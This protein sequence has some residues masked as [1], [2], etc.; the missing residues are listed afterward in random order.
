MRKYFAAIVVIG[1]CT[2]PLSAEL[3]VTSKMVARQVAGA[4]AGNDMMAAMVGPMIT[5]MYGGADGV[6]MIV[7]MHEDGRMRTDY[8]KGFAGMPAGAVV[9]LRADGSSVGFDDKARTWWKMAGPMD[10]PNA[11]AMLAQLKPQVATKR[12]GEFATIAGLKAERVSMTMVMAVPLPPGAENMPP[13]MMAMIPKEI[14]VEGDN[15]VAQAHAKYMKTMTKVLAQGPL[16]GVGIDK[17]L[18]DLQ[19]LS[20]RQVVRMSML[21]GWEL[22]TLVT[23]VAEEDTPDTVFDLPSGYKEIPMPTPIR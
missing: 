8:P 1:L 12:T 6:D 21:A 18:N 9:I 15:W 13:E 4:P 20:V 3:K 5:Q 7:T 14:K 16:A 22:E 11:K 23:K 2:A 10:D 19:G 17:L